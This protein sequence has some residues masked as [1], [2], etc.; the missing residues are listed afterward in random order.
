MNKSNKGP[1]QAKQKAD[2]QTAQVTPAWRVT[3]LIDYGS[4]MVINGL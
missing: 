2:S 1:R 3:D 4:R